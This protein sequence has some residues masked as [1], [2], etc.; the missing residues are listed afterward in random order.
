M[1]KHLKIFLIVIVFTGFSFPQELF[2]N[3]PRIAILYSGLSEKYDYIN[4][5]KVVDVITSWELFLMQYDIPYKVIYDEDIE[6]GISDD[7][8]VLILP[9][10]NFIS[11]SQIEK[12]QKYLADG[13][14]IIN[15]GSK[16][17][18]ENSSH[19]N[20]QNLKTLFKLIDIESVSSESISFIHS[21]IPNQLNHFSLN[22]NSVLQIS[23]INQVLQ[24][25]NFEN[26]SYQYGFNFSENKLSTPKSSILFGTVGTGKYLWIGFDIT[27]LVGGKVNLSAFK[28]LITNSI[29][30]MD[31][32][33]DVY[34]DNF[35]DSISAPII[36]S[37]Q[38]N[39]ALKPDLIDDLH[40]N[41]IKPVLFVSD[42]QIISKEVLQKFD[43]NEIVLDLSAMSNL[44]Q[45]DLN[46][47][48]IK[49]NVNYKINLTSIFV[50]KQFL[51]VVDLDSINQNGIDK[52][53]YSNQTFGLPKLIGKNILT[54][55]FTKNNSIRYSQSSLNF[56]YY[57]PKFNCKTDLDYEL[58]EEI[59]QLKTDKYNFASLNSLQ[60]WWNIRDKISS[61]ISFISE[62]EIEILITNKN[63]VEVND[64][65]VYLTINN[66]IDKKSMIITFSTTSLDYDFDDIADIVEIKLDSIHP[67]SVNKIKLSF[68]VD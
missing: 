22:D 31:D 3:Q 59:N 53:L 51:N 63:S 58:I 4:S 54:I 50:D 36:T 21:I 33:P 19:N 62:N 47:A 1:R 39:N 10:V 57:N 41:N 64:L 28:N 61:Q 5:T 68:N 32:K 15:A 9:S 66:K 29:N 2:Y 67:N 56:L 23:T 16:L 24:S 65:K 12:L 55:P 6:S 43:S 49:F 7:F 60:K 37:I 27:D 45:D 18:F 48:L 35:A 25:D 20:F 44:T 26:K 8:D 42:D 40:N 38:Y 13:K 46:E 14:S 30:W 52:V 17:L 11:D 34:I